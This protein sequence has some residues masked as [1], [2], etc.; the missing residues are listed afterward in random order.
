MPEAAH[1]QRAAAA[2]CFPA[3]HRRAPCSSHRAPATPPHTPAHLL[4][5]KGA[6]LG[7]VL[8]HIDAHHRQPL[9][10]EL[11]SQ[12]GQVGE[13]HAAGA[14]PARARGQAKRGED[15][16]RRGVAAGCWPQTCGM[17]EVICHTAADQLAPKRPWTCCRWPGQQRVAGGRSGP[18]WPAFSH[19]VAQNSMTIGPLRDGKATGSPLMKVSPAGGFGGGSSSTGR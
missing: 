12:L 18:G 13:G 2:C 11:A 9:L 17:K 16:V 4:L 1:A 19:Q 14:A 6:D 7:A 3:A 15:S 8:L 10:P 5:H